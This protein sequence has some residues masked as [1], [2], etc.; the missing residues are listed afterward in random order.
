MDFSYTPEQ[1]LLRR[2][3]VAFARGTLNARVIERDRDQVFSRD[4][5]HAC[6]G[7]GVQGLPVPPEYGGIGA[8]PLTCAVA[9]EALGYGCTDH[10]LVF[11]LCAHVVSCV[12]PLA[13]FG[14]EEQKRR[15][16]PG[17]CDGTSIGVHAMT[18]AGA[19]SD[20]FSMRSRAVREGSGWRITGSKTFISNG[21]EADVIIVFAL[22]DPEARFHGGVTA[23]VVERGAPG[24]SSGRKIEKMGLRTSPFAEVV[25]E[26]VR[27]GDDAVLGGIG[28]G[29]GVFAHSMDWER[30]CLFAAHVGQMERLMEQAIAHARTRKSGHGPIGRH[31]AVS[32]KIADMKIRLEA[33]R[34]LTYHA[35]SKLDVSRS[36]TLDAAVTKVFVSEALV[37]TAMDTMQI[38][39]G[40]GYTTEHEVER[41]VRDALGAP[42]YSGTS[43][44]Q[45]NI[46][47]AWLGL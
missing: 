22:T 26:D 13:K 42:I 4:L 1:E 12:V 31:Q 28:A 10:G 35:A 27:V 34:L 8:D 40:Y 45:R 11:S 6:A 41:A 20:P 43:E 5:W 44:V 46:I 9:L 39:G 14:A 25:F 19:G 24:L 30:V 23:F 17:L 47:A 29:A 15:Y 21:G 38:F 16:L 18:E 37:K 33:A 3:I 7:L 32:H 36:V 2:E